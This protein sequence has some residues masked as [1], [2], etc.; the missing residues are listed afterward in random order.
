MLDIL[1]NNFN[2][3]GS[4][5]NN[6]VFVNESRG[7]SRGPRRGTKSEREQE[8]RHGHSGHSRRNKCDD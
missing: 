6:N 8:H 2:G 4:N 7:G 5:R 1:S 3:N